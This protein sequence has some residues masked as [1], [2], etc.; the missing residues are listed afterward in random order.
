MPLKIDRS[1]SYFGGDGHCDC[2]LHSKLQFQSRLFVLSAVST[3][4]LQLIDA[5]R[6]KQTVVHQLTVTLDTV[7]TTTA[8]ATT[9][10]AAATPEQL[11]LE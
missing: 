3:F 8:L 10:A 1:C 6:I 4:A 5:V 2:N 11:R 7:A 9:T